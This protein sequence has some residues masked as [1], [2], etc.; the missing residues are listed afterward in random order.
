MQR[1]SARGNNKSSV[2]QRFADLRGEWWMEKKEETALLRNGA[3]ISRELHRKV[4][5]QEVEM[6]AT[7]RFANCQHA[8]EGSGT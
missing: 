7:R 6:M 5:K 8:Q 1:R 3:V 2:V 4:F